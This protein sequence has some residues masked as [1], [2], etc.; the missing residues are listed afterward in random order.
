MNRMNDLNLE[1]RATRK[2]LGTLLCSIGTIV[3]YGYLIGGTGGYLM[4]QGKPLVA[5]AGFIGGTLLAW[6]ALRLWKSY[7]ID[8]S[9]LN[10]RDKKRENASRKS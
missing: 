2:R 4:G 9:E 8:A 7:L 10:E 5:T 3:S 6:M 1:K